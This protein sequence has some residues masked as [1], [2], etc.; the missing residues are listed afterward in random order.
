MCWWRSKPT[1]CSCIRF[2]AVAIH[3][4]LEHHTLPPPGRFRDN[5]LDTGAATKFARTSIESTR[6]VTACMG[7]CRFPSPHCIISLCSSE[8]QSGSCAVWLLLFVAR[9]AA[10]STIQQPSPRDARIQ[11]FGEMPVPT[12]GAPSWEIPAQEAAPAKS[13]SPNATN[14]AALQLRAHAHLHFRGKTLRE[15]EGSGR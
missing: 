13:S 14:L 7:S 8:R 2:S 4:Q 6:P 12:N 3:R 10:D 9:A 1:S 11:Q 5:Y 15:L